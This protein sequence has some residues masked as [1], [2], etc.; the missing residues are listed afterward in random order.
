MIDHFSGW[1]DAKFLQIPTTKKVIDF[2]RQ[3][4]AQYGV[5]IKIRTDPGTLYVSE[6][7]TQFCRQSGIEDITSPIRD[8]R[9]NGK[10]ERLIRTVNERLRANKQIILSKDKTGLSEIFY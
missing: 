9:G 5:P 8:Y 1:P 3:F 4:C 6:V 2:L 7:F 10:I